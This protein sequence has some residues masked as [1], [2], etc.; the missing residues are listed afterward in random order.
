MKYY[1]RIITDERQVPA[2][3]VPLTEYRADNPSEAKL[4]STIHSKGEIE[5]VKLMRT[6]NDH[7]GKVWVDKNQADAALAEYHAPAEQ[8][9]SSAYVK[10]SELL[11]E[12]KII[13]ALLRTMQ[14]VTEKSICCG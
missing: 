3:Y 1:T 10:N 12:L 13:S 14:P 11:A 6:I 8:R 4:L 9:L 7:G 2:G 5:A